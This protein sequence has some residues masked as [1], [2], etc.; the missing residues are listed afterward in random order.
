[1]A[2]QC[3]AL[4]WPTSLEECGPVEDPSIVLKGTA[5]I[6]GTPAAVVAI[7]IKLDLRRAPD[8]KN[9]LPA[10]VYQVD[11]LETTLDELDYLVNKIGV[12]TGSM[13]RRAVRLSTGVYVLWLL[14]S[15]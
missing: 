9:G 14:P 6:G 13:E 12:I 8:Y 11:A 1:M 3:P 10:D 2:I 7:R 4:E 5:R 15:S